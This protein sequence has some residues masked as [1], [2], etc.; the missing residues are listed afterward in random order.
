[1]NHNKTASIKAEIFVE[2]SIML[3]LSKHE[4]EL[5]LSDDR[6]S[7]LESHLKHHTNTNLFDA[8]NFTLLDFFLW[9]V[10]VKT[11]I[12]LLERIKK[13]NIDEST[14]RVSNETSV[15]SLCRQ[16]NEKLV[17]ELGK[18]FKAVSFKPCFELSLAYENQSAVIG[19]VKLFWHRV[20]EEYLNR[21]KTKTNF[22]DIVTKYEF[23]LNEC[24]K[25]GFDRKWW[26][27]IRE[28]LDIYEEEKT[29]S[30]INMGRF[31][32]TLFEKDY[33]N[34][35]HHQTIDLEDEN[36]EDNLLLEHSNHRG[37]DLIYKR[38]DLSQLSNNPVDEHLLSLV[39]KSNRNDL[40][41]HKTTKEFIDIKWRHLP[42]TIY[43]LYLGFYT[44]F[45][46]LYLIN[47]E[48]VKRSDMKETSTFLRYFLFFVGIL[49]SV[50]EVIIYKATE[51]KYPN[52]LVVANFPLCV[53]SLFVDELKWIKTI[54]YAI[55]V[56]LM[57]VVLVIRSEK[58]TL[59]KIGFY[60]A[61]FKRVVKRSFGLIPIA[62]LC[63]IAFLIA[64]RIRPKVDTDETEFYK[65]PIVSSFVRLLTMSLGEFET[66]K[67]GFATIVDYVIFVIYVF[68]L[69]MMVVNMFIG[70]AVDEV[71][72]LAD[73]YE[74]WAIR[75]RI[76]YV[77]NVQRAF[78]RI[79]RRLT[80]ERFNRL[81]DKSLMVQV[82]EVRLI[83]RSEQRFNENEDFGRVEEENLEDLSRSRLEEPSGNE[84][85]K[86]IGDKI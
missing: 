36:Q 78:E 62:L 57:F 38:F 5:P 1:M 26:E 69:P 22:L 58:I 73:E 67:M 6:S 3:A 13:L 4:V 81:V 33:T 47:L 14:F 74:I 10:P 44:A 12:N 35:N 54:L 82:D 56:I 86:S 29:D 77:L 51:T 30:R 9:F 23:H 53:F 17:R 68:L 79:A 15:K 32:L 20:K 42:K 55:S 46:I 8:K 72:R 60:S 37:G 52:P 24:V 71:R 75:V 19:F 48:I 11:L 64:F 61:G 41:Q 83:N 63:L 2:Y 50:Q 31:Y 45:L 7:N 25:T 40:I 70:V 16:G 28:L 66:S 76:G 39:G 84:L 59:L 49:F 18:Y 27:L 65:G 21:D 34:F 80:R 43:K 85:D